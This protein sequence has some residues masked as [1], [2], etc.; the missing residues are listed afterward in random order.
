MKPINFDDLIIE[1]NEWDKSWQQCGE[2]RCRAE[3]CRRYRD[4]LLEHLETLTSLELSQIDDIAS[5]DYERA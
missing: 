2:P 3:S 1:I 4:A 5:Y